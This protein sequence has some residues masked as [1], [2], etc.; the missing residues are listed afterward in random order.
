LSSRSSRITIIA[1]ERRWSAPTTTSGTGGGCPISAHTPREEAKPE[2][3]ER[4]S[5]R[6][7]RSGLDPGG[8]DRRRETRRW[9]RGRADGNGVGAASPFL[10]SR[11]RS[12]RE[13]RS[14]GPRPG[15][16][17]RR[18]PGWKHFRFT[19]LMI[20]LRTKKMA[21]TRGRSYSVGPS[22]RSRSPA[23][24][25]RTLH[26]SHRTSAWRRCRQAG[27][28]EQELHVGTATESFAFAV[29]V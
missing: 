19:I 9:R 15:I 8:G 1:A 23:A 16:R 12:V 7:H 11:Y 24:S 13:T 20:G 22:S 4:C 25:P 18:T 21:A 2:G 27:E 10:F 26:R 14:V 29:G 3:M 5:S 28:V 6:D 17:T